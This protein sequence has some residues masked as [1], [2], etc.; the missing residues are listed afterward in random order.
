MSTHPGDSGR[1]LT[2]EPLSAPLEQLLDVLDLTPSELSAGRPSDDAVFAA[3]SLHQPTGRVYGGQVLAQ[4]LLAAGATVDSERLPHS[5]H[6]YFLRAGDVRQAVTLGVER[7]RDG[8][9]F[10]TR[11]THAYQDGVPILSMI[12]SFQ[13]EQ[14]GLEHADPAPQAPA[15]ESLPSALELLGEIDHPVAQFWSTQSAFDIRHVEGPIYLQPGSSAEADQAVWMR[16]RGPVEGSQLLHRAVLAYACDQLM[17]EPVLRSA[18]QSWMTP[19]LNLASLDHAMWWHR[20]VR[21]DEWLLY[22]QHSASSHGGR[23]LGTAQVFAQDGT[24]VASIAQEG[25][26]RVPDAR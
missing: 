19:G 9:S 2:T 26:V 12:A 16:S 24:L 8:R 22:V 17:L 1:P 23:G 3:S 14:P 6:G 5:L 18:G 15:P 4:S 13:L 21:V 11:R 25:M 20:D 7:L 10:A